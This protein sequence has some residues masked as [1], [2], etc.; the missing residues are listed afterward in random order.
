[1]RPPHRAVL[2]V[3]VEVKFQ[4]REALVDRS[5]KKKQKKLDEALDATFPASDPLAQ[6]G[7]GHK[8]GSR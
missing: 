6:R 4:L 2:C 5:N 7:E 1:V 8:Q 3:V